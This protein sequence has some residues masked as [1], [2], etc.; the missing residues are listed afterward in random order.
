[1][2]VRFGCSIYIVAKSRKEGTDTALS[3]GKGEEG[4]GGGGGGKNKIQI[5]SDVMVYIFSFPVNY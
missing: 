3:S 4:G 5:L 2:V 1:M